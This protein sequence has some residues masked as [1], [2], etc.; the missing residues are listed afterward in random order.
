MTACVAT[1]TLAQQSAAA[2]HV[3]DAGATSVTEIVVTANKREQNLSKV[4]ESVSALSAKQLAVRRIAT[5]GDLARATPGM[6]FAPTPNSTPVYTIRGV[7]FYE[8][9]LAAYP[10]VALYIDQAPLPLPIMS[11]LTAFDLE[12]VEVL[13][14]PQGTLFG[15][16]ATGGAIN[17][18]AAKPTT[19]LH[20]GAEV[21]Y[22]RF[23]TAEGSGYISGP[24]ADTLQARLA[25]K[26]ARGGDWQESY[27][28]DDTLG[29]LD[30]TAGRLIFDWEPT[31][32]LKFSL[33]LNGWQDRSDPQAPQ[34]IANTP[35][36]AAPV[37]YP[38]LT[39]PNAPGNAR[40]ADWD[41]GAFRP[42]ANNRFGQAALRT[43]YDFGA[44]TLTSITNFIS[45][46]ANNATE[47]GGTA[48]LDLDLYRDGGPIRSFT[49]ELRLSNGSAKSFRWVVG[50][51]YERTT[52]TQTSAVYYGDTTSGFANNISHNAYQSESKMENFAGFANVEYDFTPQL[53]FKGGVRE[54][55]ANRD[56]SVC[57]YDDASLPNLPAVNAGTGLPFSTLTNFFNGIY[58]FLY[59]G[60]V[61][62]IPPGGCITLDNRPNSPT[63]LTAGAYRNKLDQS[64]TSWSTGID[65][66]PTDDLLFYLNVAKGYKAGSFPH[67]VAVIATAY[68][69]V[70]QE[71]VLD[72]EGGA[73]AQ[74][75]DRRL[76]VNGSVFYYDYGDKQL[77]A[78]F[79]DPIFGALDVLVNVP[80][81]HVFG[82]EGSVQA[83]PFRGLTFSASA[84]YLSAVVDN[85]NGVVGSTVGP[86]G[87]RVPTLASFKGVSLP[88]SPKFSYSLRADYDR[89][90]NDTLAAFVGIGVNGQSSTSAVLTTLGLPSSLFQLNAH[91]VVDANVG[92]RSSDGRW[93]LSVY[94]T[95][96]LNSYYWNNAVQTY[97]S[98]VRYA[99]RPAE[100]G[101]S[102]TVQF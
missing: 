14:G 53:T 49:Q 61:P 96:I 87:L 79:I 32:R 4:G 91:S 46:T 17:F 101:A 29:K 70:N 31:S 57:V 34:K 99:G 92:I 5:V 40:A 43:D 7:G 52:V 26:V 16:N 35:Q 64:N 68:S 6:T 48:L 36:N 75:F 13:K 42:F 20:E 62:T 78:K 82:T 50:A 97:D 51:N 18:I 72:F 81:S 56:F 11:S 83:S 85:Y 37:G 25:V 102:L 76:S 54:T 33:D 71:S 22:G 30:T 77:R 65:F 86:D 9:S 41:T 63:Y 69:P 100:Y 94:G 95:N 2:P 74:L 98:V 90:I 44:A 38:I 19:E 12:R 3:A 84:T 55:Q 89:P 15:N 24:I 88:F 73:K 23:G 80:Q 60:K 58:G 8:T 10:D 45:M 39:V 59:D 47:G 66:K 28:R 21:S 93:R 1:P 27:T 67:L